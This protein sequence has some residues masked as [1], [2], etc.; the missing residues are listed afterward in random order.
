ME[1]FIAIA[2]V[3]WQRS[4]VLGMIIVINKIMVA[5]HERIKRFTLLRI[6]V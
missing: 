2:N 6:G 4:G 5:I 3:D 1:M